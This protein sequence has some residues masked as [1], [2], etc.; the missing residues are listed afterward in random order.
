MRVEPG[1]ETWWVRIRQAGGEVLGAGVLLDQR[2]V[3]TCAHV[4]PDRAEEVVAE[5]VGRPGA[6]AVPATVVSWVPADDDQRGDLALL[7]LASPAPPGRRPV[8]RRPS[9]WGREVYTRGFPSLLDDGLWVR[10]RLGGRAGPGG[11]WVQ[12]DAEPY[13]EIHPGF[14]G[15]P[16]VDGRSG[17]VLGI[18]VS[19]FPGLAGLAWMIPVETIVRHLPALAGMVADN[20]SLTDQIRE[21]FGPGRSGGALVVVTG[22]APVSGSLTQPAQNEEDVSGKSVAEVSRRVNRVLE[23]HP[24]RQMFVFDAVDEAADPENLAREVIRPLTE[25]GHQVITGLRQESTRLRGILSVPSVSRRLEVLD[26]RIAEA[27]AAARSARAEHRRVARLVTPVPDWPDDGPA[28][29]LRANGLRK[30]PTLSDL[31][32]CEQQTRELLRKS[33]ETHRELKRIYDEYKSLKSLLRAYH[34]GS[35]VERSERD[36]ILAERYSR[37]HNLLFTVPCDLAAASEAVDHYIRALR[38]SP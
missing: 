28:L 33:T 9:L 29:Q 19:E 23:R 21:F 11:E 6:R 4:I 18:V 35:G 3:L 1:E 10:A 38:E 22:D 5:F 12:M 17:D 13:R 26:V 27:R 15:A 16:V 24:E 34:L 20:P 37:A 31:E 30:N 2:T 7:D 36:R 25:A 8:L 32:E 14:S